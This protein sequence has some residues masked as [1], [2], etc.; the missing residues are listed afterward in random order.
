MKNKYVWESKNRKIQSTHLKLFNGVDSLGG[1]ALLGLKNLGLVRPALLHRQDK[2]ET[3]KH[4]DA[5]T[6]GHLEVQRFLVC[7]LQQLRL[8]EHKTPIHPQMMGVK[9]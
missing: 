7:C 2:E 5:I 9:W 1:G 6:A 8:V 3:G 4:N